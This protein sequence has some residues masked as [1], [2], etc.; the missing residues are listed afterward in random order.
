MSQAISNVKTFRGKVKWFNDAKG[1]GFVEHTSGRDVFIHYSVIESDGYKTLKDGELIDYDLI[2][3]DK[4][5]HAKK[6]RRVVTNLSNLN[7]E[8]IIEPPKEREESTLVTPDMLDRD[9]DQLEN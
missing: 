9:S 1:Y 6:V 2:E 3:G 8:V 5:L 7:I 4:G